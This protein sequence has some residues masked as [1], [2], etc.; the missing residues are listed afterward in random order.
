MSYVVTGVA[1]AIGDLGISG[2]TW[3]P[4]SGGGNIFVDV[5]VPKPDRCVI[6]SMLDLDFETTGGLTGD[7]FAKVQVRVRGRTAS[8]AYSTASGVAEGLWAQRLGSVLTDAS[9]ASYDLILGSVS[10]PAYMGVDNN[11]R[12]EYVIRFL[13]RYS[14]AV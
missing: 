8:E 7:R 9:G 5:V 14:P 13:F 4:S 12:P 1:K 10:G 6:V 3:S 11:D 2:L